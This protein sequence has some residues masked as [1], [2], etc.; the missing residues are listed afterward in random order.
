[1]VGTIEKLLVA[2]QDKRIKDAI[3]NIVFETEAEEQ[4]SDLVEETSKEVIEE[5]KLQNRILVEEK[6]KLL[7]VLDEKEQMYQT[8]L[9][10]LD[11]RATKELETLQKQLLCSQDN[12]KKHMQ[13]VDALKQKVQFYENS[14]SKLEAVFRIYRSLGG[15]LHQELDRVLCADNAELFLAWG[16]QWENLEAL[17]DFLSYRVRDLNEDD[18][19]A[20]CYVFDYLFEVYQKVN[21]SYERLAVQVGDEFDE[22]IHTRGLNSAVGGTITKVLLQGYQAVHKDKIKKSIV[23]I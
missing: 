10:M 22:D 20:L 4:Q 18:R 21:F 2:L 15:E 5:L 3:R 7:R 8:E 9:Q 1:M 16:T 6:E 12:E 19:V 11:D 14:Y 13:I 17:W 23:L